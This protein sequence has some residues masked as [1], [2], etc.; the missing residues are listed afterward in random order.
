MNNQDQTRKYN[1]YNV[2]PEKNGLLSSNIINGI[3]KNKNNTINKTNI[4]LNK[5]NHFNF[6]TYPKKL[7]K[8][9]KWEE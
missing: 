2:G 8:V 4:D 3:F 1:I 6:F 7:E 5:E 9:I